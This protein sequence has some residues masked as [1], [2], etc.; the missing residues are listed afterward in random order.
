MADRFPPCEPFQ[1]GMLSVS[2]GQ[3]IYWESCGNPQGRPA[4]FLHGGPGSGCGA[5]ARRYFDPQVYHAVLFDQRGCGR[6]RPLAE[7]D[8]SAQTMDA[9]VDDIE[10]L[11]AHLNFP[12]W[13]VVL[14]VSWGTTLALAYTFAQRERV[15]SLVLALVTT[16]SR[17]EVD[18]I[19]RDVGRLFPESWQRFY[20][21]IPP[22]LRQL[23]P[24]E[25][26]AHMLKEDGE[27]AHQAALE[28]CRW[29]EAHVSLQP[30]SS[31]PA[32]SGWSY[33]AFADASFRLRFARLVTHYWSHGAFLDDRLLND[34]ESLQG[35]PGTLLHGRFD[36]SSPWETPWL[37]AQRWKTCRLQMLSECGHGGPGFPEAVTAALN[38][39][40]EL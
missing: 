8:L 34:A 7:R 38:A 27:L 3:Q 13:Q 9:L 37:L 39:M 35:L 23:R 6:S 17:R 25:A 12:H 40:A 22:T 14:G 21:L 26:Y 15:R 32:A 18:W 4:L 5:G 2:D 11:R 28:W 33:A 30:G 19:T 36:V 24:V 16:T 29:E 1:S 20:D 31:L 10:R